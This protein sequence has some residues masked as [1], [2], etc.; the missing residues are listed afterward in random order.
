M[1]EIKCY[2]STHFIISL[3]RLPER[4]D[5]A[6]LKMVVVTWN[7]LVHPLFFGYQDNPKLLL[8][9]VDLEY[10][11]GQMEED[12]VVRQLERAI[13]SSTLALEHR[14]AFSQ[15]RL[16]FLED[17]GTKV[18]RSVEIRFLSE[19]NQVVHQPTN[20]WYDLI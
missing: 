15:R 9:L 13:N 1:I 5:K 8:Q 20:L 16:E 17:F 7:T 10:N 2:K 6:I 18:D 19:P 14:V 3:V 12:D 4:E 11:Q